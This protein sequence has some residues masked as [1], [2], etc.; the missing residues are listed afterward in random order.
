VGRGLDPTHRSQWERSLQG[1]LVP[2]LARA[3]NC[4]LRMLS[5]LLLLWQCWDFSGTFLR[6]S[7][8]HRVVVYS[9]ERFSK[10]PRLRMLSRF[11]AGVLWHAAATQDQL[12]W[13]LL[14]FLWCPSLPS[15]S[16]LL[17]PFYSPLPF[18]LLSLSIPSPPSIPPF[19]LVNMNNYGHKN[20][21]MWYPEL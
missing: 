20:S 12:M 15:L 13:C 18:V 11:G 6:S 14:V 8:L 3:E 17:S 10:A 5:L 19:H 4:N 1:S 21:V 7:L 2:L 9:S 16:L